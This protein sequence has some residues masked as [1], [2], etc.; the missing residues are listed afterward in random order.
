M[1]VKQLQCEGLA[2]VN[3]LIEQHKEKNIFLYFCGAI[4][5]TGESWCPDC[6]NGKSRSP[7]HTP[8]AQTIRMYRV[9]AL[10]FPHKSPT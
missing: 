7:L 2:N 5:E 1:R 6:R 8:K 10:K 4:D 3:E 9:E